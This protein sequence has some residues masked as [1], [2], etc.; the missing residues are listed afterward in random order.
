MDY[1]IEFEHAVEAIEKRVPFGSH[2]IRIILTLGT[3]YVLFLL[4]RAMSRDV[5]DPAA[6][7]VKSAIAG[8]PISMPPFSPWTFVT[9]L[10]LLLI[11]EGCGIA[12]GCVYGEI[13]AL[14]RGTKRL[15]VID[16]AVKELK[17]RLQPLERGNGKTN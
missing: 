11:G 1:L 13:K 7:I 16:Q 6:S 8:H 14:E 10:I 3:F 4:L 5:F 15:D 9:A 17:A 2:L 12:V